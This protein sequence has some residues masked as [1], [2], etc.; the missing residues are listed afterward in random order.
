M[1][2]RDI[3]HLLILQHKISA[4][5]ILA[6]IYATR[7]QKHVNH[8]G[9]GTQVKSGNYANEQQLLVETSKN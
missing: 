8:I 1:I 7:P 3:L 6:T 5:Y 4:S 2:H 9:G